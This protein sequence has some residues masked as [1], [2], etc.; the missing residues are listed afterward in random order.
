MNIDTINVMELYYRSKMNRNI[1]Q[2]QQALANY[3]NLYKNSVKNKNNF[4]NKIKKE[5]SEDRASLY[6]EQL[7]Y[8]LKQ[9]L[10]KQRFGNNVDNLNKMLN[11]RKIFN[12]NNPEQNN[13]EEMKS[14]KNKDFIL[15]QYNYPFLLSISH[16]FGTT[17]E[18]GVIADGIS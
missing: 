16:N 7:A 9:S 2:S 5:T 1:V 13:N 6:D 14:E 4:K 3:N 17:G 10:Y 11:N 18:F 8:L 15:K 12:S